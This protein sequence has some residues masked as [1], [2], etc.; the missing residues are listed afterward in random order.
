[1]NNIEQIIVN[2]LNETIKN[3][4]DKFCLVAKT[5]R[6]LGCYRSRGGAEKREKQVQYHH[7]VKVL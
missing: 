7:G 4:G 6:N 5:G 2:V 3:R 1:M